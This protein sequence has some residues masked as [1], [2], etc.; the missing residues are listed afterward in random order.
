[1]RLVHSLI[2]GD[3]VFGGSP[4]RVHYLTNVKRKSDAG[5]AFYPKG[6]KNETFQPNQI[7]LESLWRE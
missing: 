4:I 7:E 2:A 1:M 3:C 6:A 5:L